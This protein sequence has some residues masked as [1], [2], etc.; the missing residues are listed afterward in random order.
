MLEQT[1]Q[2]TFPLQAEI[3]EREGDDQQAYFLFFRHAHLVLTH[4]VTHPDARKLLARAS[5]AEAQGEVQKNLE[6]LDVLRP[7][8]N[9]KYE[10]YV[11]HKREAEARRA[12]V[13]AERNPYDGQVYDALVPYS[14]QHLEASQN[15]ELAISM[16][17]REI[18]RRAAARSVRE[19][20]D[21]LSRQIQQVAAH[22]ERQRR[23]AGVEQ[24]VASR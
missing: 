3:Y 8:I 24:P 20:D 6:R 11:R 5:L 18:S 16:A 4:L 14:G 17:Q 22:A 7:R 15:S 1:C 10:E 13:Q 12:V 23:A 9:N 2:L 21:D 19:D